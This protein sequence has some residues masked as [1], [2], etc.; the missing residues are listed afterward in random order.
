MKPLF[1]GNSNDFDLSAA[2]RTAL[3]PLACRAVAQI[4]A[5]NEVFVD[6][7]AVSLSN[8]L[9]L[10]RRRFGSDRITRRAVILRSLWFERQLRWSIA[11][12]PTSTGSS[13]IWNLG[14][15]FDTIAFRFKEELRSAS[16]WVDADLPVVTQIKA[17]SGVFAPLSQL[18]YQILPLDLSQ[19]DS[20]TGLLPNQASGNQQLIVLLQGVLMYLPTSVVER[21]LQTLSSIADRFAATRVIFDWCSPLLCRFSRLHPGLLR[22]GIMN[23]PFRWSLRSFEQLRPSMQNFTCVSNEDSIYDDASFTT[24]ILKRI[25][26]M[27]PPYNSPGIYGCSILERRSN[28]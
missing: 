28:G 14:S 5:E 12:R 27:M 23:T 6:P 8:Y 20:L 18:N 1:H 21:L 25:L 7:W 19:P 26:L 17:A 22:A 9:R 10:D 15:G 11:N 3:V 16:Y 13:V 2:S 24:R 4:D